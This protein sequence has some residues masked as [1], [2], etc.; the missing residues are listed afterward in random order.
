MV[1]PQFPLQNAN[2]NLPSNPLIKATTNLKKLTQT[3]SFG[4]EKA[5]FLTR[6]SQF[7]NYLREIQVSL[8]L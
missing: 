2:E 5:N 4:I 6:R 1:R 8:L 7:N 3:R